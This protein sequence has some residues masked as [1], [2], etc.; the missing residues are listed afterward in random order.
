MSEPT[1]ILA[2]DCG[3]TTTKLVLIGEDRSLLHTWYSANK[4]DPVNLLKEQLLNI[5]QLCEDRIAIAGSAVTGYG[6]DLIRHALHID[7]GL[8][9]T[10]A[11]YKAASHFL[12]EADFILDIGGQDIKCFRI[13]NGAIDSIMLNEACSSGCGSSRWAR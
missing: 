5:Y 2:T 9:E 12:P 4:G 3:S 10:I 6:E 13:R 7:E 1:R 11:H 8:V